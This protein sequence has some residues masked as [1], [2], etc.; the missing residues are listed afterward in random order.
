MKEFK[1]IKEFDDFETPDFHKDKR[2]YIAVNNKIKELKP[3]N[4]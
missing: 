3:E 1:E 4:I 2:V